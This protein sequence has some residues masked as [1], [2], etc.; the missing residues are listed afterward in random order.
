MRIVFTAIILLM[1]AGRGASQ[2]IDSSAGENT[3]SILAP[4]A[5][6]GRATFPPDSERAAVYIE[7]RFRNAGLKTWNGSGSYRQPFAMVRATPIS[8][9]VTFGDSVLSAPRQVISS[10]AELNVNQN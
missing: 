4:D 10:A 1:V 5:M 8:A 9:T 7:S 6:R 2:T 3:E